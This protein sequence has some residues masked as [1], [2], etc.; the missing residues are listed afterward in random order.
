MSKTIATYTT[1]MGKKIRLVLRMSNERAAE[2]VQ[3][4][5][6]YVAKHVYKKY[7]NGNRD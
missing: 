3:Q 4:G 5:W 6:H 1:V 2:L 7:R